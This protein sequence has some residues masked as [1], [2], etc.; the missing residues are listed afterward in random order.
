MPVGLTPVILVKLKI[1]SPGIARI[2][3]KKDRYFSSVIRKDR[4]D[5][6]FAKF[7]INNQEQSNKT[8]SVLIG[9]KSV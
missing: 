5:T 4:K 6:C 1:K 9:A 7:K 8:Y 3:G 2:L